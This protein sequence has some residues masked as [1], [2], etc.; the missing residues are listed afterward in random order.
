MNSGHNQGGKTQVCIC[1]LLT[2]LIYCQTLWVNIRTLDALFLS[3]VQLLRQTMCNNLKFNCS[4]IYYTLYMDIFLW[5]VQLLFLLF[6]LICS[7]LFFVYFWD[8][9]CGAAVTQAISPSGVY[10]VTLILSNIADMKK[11]HRFGTL[12]SFFSRCRL[13]WTRSRIL[14]RP[15]LRCLTWTWDQRLIKRCSLTGSSAD[16]LTTTPP[17]FPS[18][19]RTLTNYKMPATPVSIN[20]TPIRIDIQDSVIND[21]IAS[22]PLFRNSHGT[23]VSPCLSMSLSLW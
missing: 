11:W 23:S 2:S 4:I 10:K 13:W 21:P 7:F 9:E 16:G 18:A 19:G 22:T 17:G 1:F 8:F 5:N 3:S 20:N 14:P 12:S 15:P 6:C